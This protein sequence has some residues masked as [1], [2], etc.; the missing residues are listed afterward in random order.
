MYVNGKHETYADFYHG[1]SVYADKDGYYEPDYSGVDTLML[2]T[3]SP[4]VTSSF[5]DIQICDE[6]CPGTDP[7]IEANSAMSRYKL[8]H[9]VI[10]MIINIL[11]LT[12]GREITG[13]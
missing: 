2:Y 10:S 1:E 5:K 3:L 13:V 6:L 9:M 4:G 11:I 12:I 7:D 8:I